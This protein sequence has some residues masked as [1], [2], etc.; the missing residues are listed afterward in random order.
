MANITASCGFSFNWIE[1]QA[2]R[3]FLNEFF[4]FA[5]PISSYQL[6]NRIIPRE[7]EKFCQAAKNRCHGSDATLQTD[8]WTGI[9]FRYL[10][11]FMITTANREAS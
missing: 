4:P 6:A 7:V 10:L 3:S 8:G 5:N 9:N 11:A 2:V 1:N